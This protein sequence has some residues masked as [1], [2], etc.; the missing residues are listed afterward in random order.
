[1]RFRR[2][3][4]ISDSDPLYGPLADNGGPTWTHALAPESP[5]VDAGDP[6]DAGAT[7]QRGFARPVDGDF[8][9]I[10]VADI[11]AVEFVGPLFSDD[12]ESGD[13]SVWAVTSP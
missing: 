12:F 3:G 2:P 11:G 10:A 5:A 1:M 8:D 13:T 6:V 4:D 9:G 7:D